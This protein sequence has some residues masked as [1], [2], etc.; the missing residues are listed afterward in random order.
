MSV[1]VS[2]D[3]MDEL[4]HQADLEVRSF[5]I[6]GIGVDYCWHSWAGWCGHKHP[7]MKIGE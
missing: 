1:L 6:V 3:R 2:S 4:Y 7:L 5:C